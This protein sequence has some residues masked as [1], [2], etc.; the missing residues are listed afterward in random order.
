MSPN[1]SVG[2]VYTATYLGP[3]ITTNSSFTPLGDAV[4]FTYNGI[5]DYI[6]KVN[7]FGALDPFEFWSNYTTPFLSITQQ[8]S[9]IITPQ[10]LHPQ[11][12]YQLHVHPATC[13]LASGSP[14]SLSNPL[15]I[16]SYNFDT[17]NN[18]AGPPPANARARMSLVFDTLR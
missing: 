3:E 18:V 14:C 17:N 15:G 10:Y 6:V 8:D 5:E 13:Q 12:A 4:K 2:D 11:D 1:S 16:L 7:A 9:A